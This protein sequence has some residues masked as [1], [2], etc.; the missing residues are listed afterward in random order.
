[1]I[2]LSWTKQYNTTTAQ[3]TGKVARNYVKRGW[4]GECHGA[5]FVKPTL[6]TDEPLLKPEFG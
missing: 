3:S 4:P 2:A 5:A 6:T 1:M